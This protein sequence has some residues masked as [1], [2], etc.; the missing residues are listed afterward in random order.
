MLTINPSTGAITLGG[1]A[2]GKST[3]GL[4]ITKIVP[5][6]ATTPEWAT[7]AALVTADPASGNM[8]AT[9]TASAT[10]TDFNA[11]TADVDFA[12]VQ[13]PTPGATPLVLTFD[14]ITGTALGTTADITVTA[15]SA[16]TNVKFEVDSAKATS[17]SWGIA[18]PFPATLDP[19]FNQVKIVLNVLTNDCEDSTNAPLAFKVIVKDGLTMGSDDVA[20]QDLATNAEFASPAL[21]KTV[22]LTYTFA[23][24]GTAASGTV[25]STAG[26][27]MQIN[28]G[29]PYVAGDIVKG[30]FEIVS[31]TFSEI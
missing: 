15:A 22:T 24:G 4:S 6:G 10:A 23:P 29:S 3:T 13:G 1:A 28:D 31:I 17:I 18:I 8:T 7:F 9:V 26:I 30:S 14:D 25:T 5:K 16:T 20:Y 12:W 2:A 27:A 11:G 19:A 21:P